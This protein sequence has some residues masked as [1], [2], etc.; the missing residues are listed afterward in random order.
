MMDDT[1]NRRLAIKTALEFFVEFFGGAF[2][3]DDQR[4]LAERIE[5]LPS[6]Q[7]ERKT[8]RWTKIHWKAFRCSECNR[9]SEFCTDFCPNCGSPMEKEGEG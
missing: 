4:L 8:G 6:A 1:I 2:R 5:A 7:P 3:E 9:L